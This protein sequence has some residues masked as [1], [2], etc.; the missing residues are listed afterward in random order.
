MIAVQWDDGARQLINVQEL[1]SEKLYNEIK[2]E[3]R[4]T[5]MGIK[6][7]QATIGAVVFAS[8]HKAPLAKGKIAG[9]V[10]GNIVIVEWDDGRLDKRQLNSLLTEVAGSAEDKR[11]QDEAERLEK[12]FAEVEQV[13]KTKLQQA[14]QLVREAAKLADAKNVD[15]QDMHEATHD[16]EYAMEAAGWRTSSWHC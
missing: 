9:P 10:T 2:E 8:G 15:L 1:M 11:L 16:L 3:E 14:A 4:L 13:C 5:L 6:A 12:E 7:E